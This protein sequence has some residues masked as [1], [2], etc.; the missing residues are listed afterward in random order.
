[1]KYIELQ[2]AGLS[3][4]IEP[5]LRH[6]WLERGL[7]A[8]S[9]AA[10]RTDLTALVE[11]MPGPVERSSRADL[12]EYLA[13][14]L[15]QGYHARS[16]ARCL[17]AIRGFYAYLLERGLIDDDPTLQINSPKL[18]RALPDHLSEEHVDC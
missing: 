16:T 13:V 11:F 18:G 17:S 2:E 9:L 7:S 8:A 6:L 5:F 15:Q 10:Y 12:L 3:D 1:M 14:R 4:Q